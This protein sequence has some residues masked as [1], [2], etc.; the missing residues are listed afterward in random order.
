MEE[1]EA[2]LQSMKIGIVGDRCATVVVDGCPIVQD[3]DVARS[4]ALLMGV[5]YALN[6]SYPK[7]LRFTFEVFQK[8]FLNLTMDTNQAPR[9]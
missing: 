4:C 3:T 6:L 8:V 2:D 7:E 9:S 1:L 5:I